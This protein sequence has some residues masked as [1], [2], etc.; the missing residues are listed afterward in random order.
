[1]SPFYTKKLY[2]HV[3]RTCCMNWNIKTDHENERLNE[4]EHRHRYGQGN[5]HG[6]IQGAPYL[7]KKCIRFEA[8]LSESGSFLLNIRFF[9]FFAYLIDSLYS[10]IFASFV[11]NIRFNLFKIFTLNRIIK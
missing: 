8:N 4:N 10:F 3:V 5:G 6:H 7:L 1:M 2:E 9:V 11:Q